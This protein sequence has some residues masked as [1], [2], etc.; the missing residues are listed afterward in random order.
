M[1]L[2]RAGG[3]GVGVFFVLSGFI[4]S[5]VY[6]D[7]FASHSIGYGKFMFARISRVYPLHLVTLLVY[8]TLGAAGLLL[9]LPQDNHY[10]FILNLGLLQAWGFTDLVSWNEPA[11]S[12]STELFAYL[13]FPFLIGPL[14]KA[15]W[16]MLIAA[17][18]LCGV[19]LTVFPY[20]YLVHWL[21]AIGFVSTGRHQF[22]YGYSLTM[23]FGVFMAGCV[24]FCVMRK[25][26]PKMTPAVSDATALAGVALLVWWCIRA[27]GDIMPWQFTLGSVL[28]VAGLSGDSGIGKMLFGNDVAFFLG[29]ISYAL[30][31][32][33]LL[34]E[35]VVVRFVWPVPLWLNLSAALVSAT[36]LHYGVEKPAQSWLKGLRRATPEP[37]QFNGDVVR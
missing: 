26:G 30:Y 22:A 21:Q 27:N 18:C 37:V 2:A 29:K 34:T 33:A 25:L 28:V 5:Y 19:W 3:T 24:A 32:S 16:R 8:G 10:T 35:A 6:A 9:L 20:N 13:L 11:W 12:I 7:K 14:T 17:A 15:G 23:F 36:I 31:L 4:L 1:K